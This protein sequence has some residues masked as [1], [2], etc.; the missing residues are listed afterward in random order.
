MTAS[1]ILKYTLAA[2]LA[3]TF[4]LSLSMDASAKPVRSNGQACDSTG[5][6]RKTGT[7]EAGNKLDCLWDTCTFSECSTS[8]GTISGCVQKTEYSNARDCKA[9]AR[10]VKGT[11]VMSVPDTIKKMKAN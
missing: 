11:G 4:A 2:V 1:A 9:A 7:D 10:G 3:G 8:G 6:A 5:T